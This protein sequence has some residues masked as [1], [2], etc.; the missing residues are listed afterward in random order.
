MASYLELKEATETL[1]PYSVLRK[2]PAVRAWDVFS[3]EYS[4]TDISD[5]T[6]AVTVGNDVNMTEPGP[7]N[8]NEFIIVSMHDLRV[9]LLESANSA[10]NL[11]FYFAVLPADVREAIH[12][13]IGTAN[14][15]PR[16]MLSTWLEPTVTKHRTY[17][18]QYYSIRKLDM[19][20]KGIY[21]TGR[22]PQDI[23]PFGVISS[24]PDKIKPAP[25][26]L[27]LELDDKG[28]IIIRPNATQR[29]LSQPSAPYS[30]SG[31]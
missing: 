20:D 3:T 13:I 24:D 21:I 17:Y 8:P 25:Q 11:N 30:V 14:T 15:G 4:L 1:S 28:G 7:V 29:D 9:L 10:D 18:G 16:I 2:H 31:P 6:P 26:A 27:I 12:L 23:L 5:A 19:D 22:S